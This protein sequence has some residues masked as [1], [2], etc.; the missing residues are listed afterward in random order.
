MLVNSVTQELKKVLEKNVLLKHYEE[1]EMK[2]DTVLLKMELTGMGLNE[3]EYED[4]R[5]LLEARLRIVEDCRGSCL[6]NGW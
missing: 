5:L 2:C 3:R 1:V 4:T 6:Q